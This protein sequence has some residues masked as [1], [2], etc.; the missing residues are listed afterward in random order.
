MDWSSII[1]TLITAGL[2]ATASIVG[3]YLT[4]EKR[5]RE[6]ETADAVKEQEQNDRL[7][8]I[9]TKL[10]IHNSYAEKLGGIQKAV[11]DLDK[12]VALIQKDIEYFKKG[13]K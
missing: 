13:S 3:S 5:R 8:S 7:K 6:E 1:T 2:A 10:I 9:E 4:N 12:S 11:T